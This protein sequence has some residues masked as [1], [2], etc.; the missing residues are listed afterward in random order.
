M[1]AEFISIDDVAKRLNIT[2][3]TVYSLV[4]RY[5]IPYERI[6]GKTKLFYGPLIDFFGESI[7]VKWG[8][9]K[10]TV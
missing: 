9:P 7:Y 10:R 6:D 5:N 3:T 8:G 4:K 2:R 1:K